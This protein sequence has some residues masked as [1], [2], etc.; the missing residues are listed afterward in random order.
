MA[1]LSN[2]PDPLKPASAIDPNI[3]RGVAGVLQK[4]MALNADE[5]PSTAAE[6]R[7]MIREHEKYGYL[8][9]AATFAV[10]ANRTEGSGHVTE[11]MPNGTQLGTY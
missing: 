10:N 1:V 5:R 7:E 6:M 4:A 11:I 9:D 8:A 2:K 3:P